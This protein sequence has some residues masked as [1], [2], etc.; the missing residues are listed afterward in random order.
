MLVRAW[1]MYCSS[2]RLMRIITGAFALRASSAGMTIETAP[3]PLLP[4]PP[5]VYSEINTTSDASMPTQLAIEPTV[6]CR[7]CVEPCRYSF[8]F[9]Q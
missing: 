9:R 7:L 1:P 5:P 3:P 8:P 6:R 4:N 2:S